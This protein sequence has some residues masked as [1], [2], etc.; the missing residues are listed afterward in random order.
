MF[1]ESQH[2]SPPVLG[3]LGWLSH[4]EIAL[5]YLPGIAAQRLPMA[6]ALV[7]AQYYPALRRAGALSIVNA[8]R[9]TSTRRPILV[10]G[11]RRLNRP[12]V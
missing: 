9:A 6:P 7:A 8:G 2:A 12:D 3:G 11:L 10:A 5:P 4:A 1:T